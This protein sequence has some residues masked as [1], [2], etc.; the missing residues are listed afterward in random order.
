MFGNSALRLA[1]SLGVA[2]VLA[3]LPQVSAYAQ[4]QSAAQSGAAQ[5]APRT[6]QEGQ[7]AQARREVVQPG[8]NAPFWRDVREGE[9]NAY[10]TTQV[11]GVETNILVQT[12]GEIWRQI[13]NGPITVYGGWLLVVV[14]LAIGL[15]YWRRGRIT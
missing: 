4:Q 2:L 14:F 9:R 13:R 6:E 5:Q 12:E 15:F 11:R 10:Q 7:Q 1:R 8:N 3:L